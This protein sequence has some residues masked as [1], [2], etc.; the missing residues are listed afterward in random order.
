MNRPIVE[1]HDSER[2]KV[3]LQYFP[4]DLPADETIESVEVSVEPEGL[5]LEGDPTIDGNTVKQMISGGE[6]W[7]D[8]AVTFNVEIS[9]GNSFE[10]SIL[11][12]IV[13]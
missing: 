3:G 1:K 6:I 13:F 12:R 5:I 8:Y 2:F 4:P 10:N 11:I 7:M 9:T